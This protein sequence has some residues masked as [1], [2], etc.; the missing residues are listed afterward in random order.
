METSLKKSL[1]TLALRC[2]E[3]FKT[4]S[5]MLHDGRAMRRITIGARG[6]ATLAGVLALTLSFSAYGAAQA[7]AGAVQ[8]SGVLTQPASPE[9]KISQ[10]R[11]KIAMMQADIAAIRRAAAVHAARVEERQALIAAVLT[12]KSD[13]AVALTTPVLDE[14]TAAVAAGVVAPLQRVEDRQV[15]LA[16]RAMRVAEARYAMTAEKIRKLGMSPERFAGRP[17]AV[18]GPFEPA[19]SHEAV[20]DLQADAQFRSLFQTWKK[21]DSLEKGVIAIPSAQPV[22]SV[23]FTSFYGVRSDPFRGLAAMHAGV[24]IPGAIGTPVYATAD[25]IVA[26]AERSGGYGNLVEVNHGRGITTRYGHL[27]KMLVA[28]NARVTR[29]QLIALMGSTGRSTGS[30]LHYE[31]RVDGHA[32]NP[33][34]FLQSPDYFSAVRKGSVKPEPLPVGAEDSTN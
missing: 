33:I 20:A 29:G 2:R 10:L 8:M 26:R 23:S 15:A 3:A 9:A 6:Q 18:G 16:A 14:K 21:L 7:A 5:V 17:A 27:S 12:G 32:V 25:G 22:A 34:P 30:H 31:V 13:A 11:G 24:D 1:L 28:P 4:R 19:T